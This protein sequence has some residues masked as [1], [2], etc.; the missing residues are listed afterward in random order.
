[1]L[2]ADGDDEFRR[3]LRGGLEEHGCEVLEASDGGRALEMLATAA[4]DGRGMP[5]AIVLE[6]RMS[7]Y[8]GL[9]VLGVVQRFPDPPAAI[10]V[11]HFID[12]SIETVARRLGALH[13]LRKPI[14]SDALLAA[15]LEAAWPGDDRPRLH[16]AP[17]TAFGSE[18]RSR[19][20]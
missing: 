1:V 18:A 3:E 13:V 10:L 11:S 20:G 19:E 4:D 15:V 6:V 14:R 5:D 16:E 2:V 9:G 17:A 8:S 7:G 12:P